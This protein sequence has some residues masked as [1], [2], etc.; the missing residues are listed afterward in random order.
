MN[1]IINRLGIKPTDV[2]FSHDL[3]PGIPVCLDK[4]VI[5]LEQQRNELL[6]AVLKFK[7][8]MYGMGIDADSE[9]VDL[10]ES[11]LLIFTN[12]IEKVCHPLKWKDIKEFIK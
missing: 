11:H 5:N 6:V 8:D 10:L 3:N 7:K 1:N 4:D 9:F 12:L 2:H